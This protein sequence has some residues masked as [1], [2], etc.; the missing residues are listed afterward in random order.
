M[1][2]PRFHTFGATLE[3]QGLITKAGTMVDASFVD[4]PWQRNTREENAMIK[5]GE[6]PADWKNQPHKLSQKDLDARW[7]KKN[8]ATFFGYKNHVRA[9][10]ESVLITEFAVTDA[11]VHHSQPLPELINKNNKDEN[12]FADSA[13]KSSKIDEKLA[14]LGIK[15]Y[16]HEKGARN[17]PLSDLQKGLNQLKSK[18]RCRIEHIFGC[19]E[20]SMGGPELEYIGRARI[21]TGIGL[22][23]LAYN[24]LRYVQLIR[25]G[26]M[27]AVAAGA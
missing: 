8:Q 9:D 10:A 2:K 13:Y 14:E 25:L 15:N 4:L 3:N 23:N 11:S 16:I 7:A 18:V 12:L 19:V 21:T 26:R 6:V 24:L 1:I 20:N 22:S 17:H 27:P 5:K